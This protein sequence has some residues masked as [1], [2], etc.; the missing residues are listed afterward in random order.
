[1]STH[2]PAPWTVRPGQAGSFKVTASPE[3]AKQSPNNQAS[4]HSMQ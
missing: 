4:F 2:L 1:M 3:R